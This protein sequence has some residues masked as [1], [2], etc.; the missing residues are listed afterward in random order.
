VSSQNSRRISI[1]TAWNALRHESGRAMIQEFLDAGFDYVELNAQI[2]AQMVDEVADMVKQGLVCI[3]SLH[4][5]CPVP[6]SIERSKAGGNRLSLAATDE[7]ERKSAVDMTKR[8]IDSACRLGAE[9][10]VLH[11]GRVAMEFRQKEALALVNVGRAEE[12]KDIVFEDLVERSMIRKPHMDSIM[13]SMHMLAEHAEAAGVKLGL[14][15][16]YY[17]GEL[18]S[19]DEFQMIFKNIPSPALGYW[20]DTGHAHTMEVL[21]IAGQEDYLKKYADKLI[22]MHIHDAVGSDD[23]QPLGRGEIDFA[24]ILPYVKPNT[25][26]VLEIHSPASEQELIG[27]RQMLINLLEACPAL[28]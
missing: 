11:L 12:A 9:T 21:G 8:T 17:Y 7:T 22:G 10:V 1:S 28:P 20:H 23:H 18:P 24:K 2:T 15:T 26:L 13:L 16:R 4:N 25:Q 14:E 6:E 19:L 3:S 27:S 5:Y